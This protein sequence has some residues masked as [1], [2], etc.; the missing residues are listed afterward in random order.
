MKAFN[1]KFTEKISKL[2]IEQI[3][4]IKEKSS[5]PKALENAFPTLTIADLKSRTSSS[6]NL[7]SDTHSACE[8]NFK[9]FI[10]D[11]SSVFNELNNPWYSP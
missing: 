10:L 7:N 4:N 5:L 6:D 3:E 8:I 9:N 11:S 2:P 1:K